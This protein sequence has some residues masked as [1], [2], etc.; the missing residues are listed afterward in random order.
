MK[1]LS[2]LRFQF[3]FFHVFFVS[4]AQFTDLNY[5][6]KN[7]GLKI[8][9]K[10]HLKCQILYF[11]KNKKKKKIIGKIEIEIGDIHIKC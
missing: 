9:I 7:I 1:S 5:I 11:W 10:V 2:K 8:F 6:S 3:S 4:R